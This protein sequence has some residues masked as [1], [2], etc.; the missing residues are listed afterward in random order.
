MK[1][2]RVR[3]GR[4][5]STDSPS[6]TVTTF[7]PRAQRGEKRDIHACV[8]FPRLRLYAEAWAAKRLRGWRSWFYAIRRG[9]VAVVFD[10]WRRWCE[11]VLQATSHAT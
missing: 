2:D 9:F 1:L 5:G 7:N 10:L 4:I 11:G 3:S 6:T 8:L